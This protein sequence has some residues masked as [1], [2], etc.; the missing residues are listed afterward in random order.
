MRSGLG[1]ADA[2]WSS[3]TARVH[4][5]VRRQCSGRIAAFRARIAACQERV[6]TIR[7]QAV[8][9]RCRMSNEYAFLRR[10]GSS[11]VNKEIHM[12]IHKILVIAL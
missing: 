1:T 4:Q 10:H 3:E 12:R 5:C 6:R 9:S 8:Q 11:S 7:S 2:I